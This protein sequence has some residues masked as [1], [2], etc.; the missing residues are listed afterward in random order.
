[1]T[2]PLSKYRVR[3]YRVRRIVQTTPTSQLQRRLG[4]IDMQQI[5]A[6]RQMIGVQ[7]LDLAF[8]AYQL[9]LDTVRLTE[10]KRTALCIT[11]R[12]RLACH[13]SDAG[14]SKIRSRIL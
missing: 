10:R 4:A 8:Q 3:K 14:Q 6:W 9:A 11:K 12:I 2:E 5:H 7:R 1:M 13:P